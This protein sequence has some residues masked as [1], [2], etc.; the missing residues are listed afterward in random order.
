MVSYAKDVKRELKLT[1]GGT[2]DSTRATSRYDQFNKFTMSYDTKEKTE[3]SWFGMK[4]TKK[5]VGYHFLNPELAPQIAK[6]SKKYLTQDLKRKMGKYIVWVSNED[7]SYAPDYIKKYIKPLV[8]QASQALR[9]RDTYLQT[10]FS[11]M[12]GGQEHEGT[13]YHTA[14]ELSG[15]IDEDIPYGMFDENQN[16]ILLDHHLLTLQDKYRLLEESIKQGNEQ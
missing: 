7:V 6:Y 14:A 11:T 13:T 15:I 16:S 12:E 8:M 4:K 10:N 1:L 2:H 5:R 9:N 3:T